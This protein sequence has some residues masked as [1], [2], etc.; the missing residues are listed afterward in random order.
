MAQAR[1]AIAQSEASLAQMEAQ[2]HL[3]QVNWD[4]YKVLVAKGVFSRQ[5]GDTQEANFRVGEAM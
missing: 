5:D 2:L 3:A 4:R 1:S